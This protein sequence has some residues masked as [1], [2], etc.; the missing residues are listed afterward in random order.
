MQKRRAQ[1]AINISMLLYISKNL[2][3]SSKRLMKI[4]AHSEL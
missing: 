3:R 2:N 1:S 4:T